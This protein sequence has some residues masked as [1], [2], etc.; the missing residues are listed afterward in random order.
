MT[1]V[2][3]TR[4]VPGRVESEGASRVIVYALIS[5]SCCATYSRPSGPNWREVGLVE[6]SPWSVAFV[7]KPIAAATA[8]AGQNVANARDRD[9]TPLIRRRI[10]PSR[11]GP[12]PWRRRGE[13]G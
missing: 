13:V 4:Y 9:R 1:L 6:V 10:A 2:A 3:V 11:I 8:E 12:W 7:L 5:P